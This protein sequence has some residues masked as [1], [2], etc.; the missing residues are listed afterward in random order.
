MATLFC[1]DC[2]VK[3]RER[4][5]EYWNEAQKEAVGDDYPSMKRVMKDIKAKAKASWAIRSEP[6]KNAKLSVKALIEE[7]SQ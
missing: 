1:L 2:E 4:E 6:I 7:Y 5:W 3:N